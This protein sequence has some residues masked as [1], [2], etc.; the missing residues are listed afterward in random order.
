ML[1]LNQISEYLYDKIFSSYSD[2]FNVNVFTESFERQREKILNYIKE[3][4]G[5]NIMDYQQ[6]NTEEEK[7]KSE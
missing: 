1:F 6:K 4:F 2:K 3:R 5:S 7:K